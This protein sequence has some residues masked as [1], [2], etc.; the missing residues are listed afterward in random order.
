MGR[1]AAQLRQVAADG[2]GQALAPG[3]PGE[4]VGLAGVGRAP[5][6]LRQA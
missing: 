4:R 6:S 5:G 1:L 3:L 2:T